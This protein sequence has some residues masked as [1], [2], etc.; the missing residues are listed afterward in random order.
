[1]QAYGAKEDRKLDV[2]GEVCWNNLSLF[3]LAFKL[4]VFYTYNIHT[5]GP[6]WSLLGQSIC[7]LV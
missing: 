1:M 3:D 2:P 6:G 4:N 5:V 7:W